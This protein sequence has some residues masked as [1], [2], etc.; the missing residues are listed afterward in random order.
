MFSWLSHRAA[1][2][3]SAAFVFASQLSAQ[4]PIVES[5]SAYRSPTKAAA[6]SN[7]NSPEMAQ[8][9][10]GGLDQ[11]ELFY[12]MQLLQQEVM[13]LRGLVEE[14]AFQLKQL[15][16][17]SM[18]RYID[19]DRRLGDLSSGK[20]TTAAP[21]SGSTPLG[22]GGAEKP[23]QAGEKEAYDTA[24]RLVIN[25]QF[26]DALEAFKQFLVDFPDGKYA[27]NS[28]YWMGELYQVITP[29]NLEAARE[30]FAQLLSQYPDHAKAPD[31]MYKLGRVYFALGNQTASREW[32]EKTI[33]LY[34]NG[35]HSSAA[36]KARQFLNANF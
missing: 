5:G 29:A 18:E 1:L 2:V 24:Y 7:N 32:L 8:Q 27:P 21:Q 36:N 30:V 9:Q 11:G 28:Y 26:D 22:A 19:L 35:A 17:Q 15:K 31:A 3:A 34:S 13:Q 20:A 23:A 33:T 14:Q 6:P 4:A 12:Q 10:S 25:K 16:E